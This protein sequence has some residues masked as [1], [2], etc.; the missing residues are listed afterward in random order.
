MKVARIGLN[1]EERAAGIASTNGP[2][3]YQ[4]TRAA[5]DSRL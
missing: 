5:A 1:D 4:Q 3:S 2:T